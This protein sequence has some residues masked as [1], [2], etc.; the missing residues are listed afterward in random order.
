MVII[1]SC[2]WLEWFI[3][4]ELADDCEKYLADPDQLLIP[5]IIIYEVYNVLKREIGEDKALLATAY[6]KGSLVIPLDEFLALAAADIALQNSLAMADAIIIA[7]AHAYNCK[8]ITS[9]SDLK[10]QK[11]VE[12][13]PK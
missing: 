13:L 6:M 8:V 12:Y 9:N 2:G 1:D 5:T 4:G 3:D 11:S 10:D 7:T